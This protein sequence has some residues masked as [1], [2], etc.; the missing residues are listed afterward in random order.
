MTRVRGGAVLVKKMFADPEAPVYP[1]DTVLLRT[2]P[3]PL[4]SYAPA[5][6]NPPLASC[7]AMAVVAATVPMLSEK[8]FT[9]A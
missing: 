7:V 8:M 3:E 5:F 9:C 2:S 6:W 4:K 1:L